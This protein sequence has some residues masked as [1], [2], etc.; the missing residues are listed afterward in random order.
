MLP[1]IIEHF[2]NCVKQEKKIK[3]DFLWKK[4]YR[5]N[6]FSAFRFEETRISAG[7]IDY[8]REFRFVSI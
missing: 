6:K 8:K 7:F 4:F 5:K 2:P 3:Q 1:M